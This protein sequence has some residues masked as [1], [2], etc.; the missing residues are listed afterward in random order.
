MDCLV[1]W[2]EKVAEDGKISEE[3]L[4]NWAVQKLSSF[5]ANCF[6]LVFI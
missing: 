4:T 5:H 6:L 3:A 2:F 1:E